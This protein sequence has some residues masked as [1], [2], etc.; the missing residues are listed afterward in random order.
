MKYKKITILVSL[1]TFTACEKEIIDNEPSTLA[2]NIG[3]GGFPAIDLLEKINVI[4][5]L[6]DAISINDL[7]WGDDNLPATLKN[8]PYTGWIKHSSGP[9]FGVGYLVDGVEH[10]P[11]L[12]KHDNGEPRISGFYSRGIRSGKW[13]TWNEDGTL[14][15]EVIWANGK[16]VENP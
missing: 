2:S 7:E 3:D 6:A 15:N 10:G 13:I 5:V 8:L 14:N 16:R 11:F 4:S 12:I 9:S 1:L